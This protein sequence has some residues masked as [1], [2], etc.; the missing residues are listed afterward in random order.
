MFR[1]MCGVNLGSVVGE[2]TKRAGEFFK[3]FGKP[4]EVIEKPTV[5]ALFY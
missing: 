3:N 1:A 4:G 5:S 2:V